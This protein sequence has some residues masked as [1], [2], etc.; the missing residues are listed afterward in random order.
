[1]KLTSKSDLS[2][3][4]KCDQNLVLIN[5]VTP[6]ARAKHE[7]FV[8]QTVHNELIL[9][10]LSGGKKFLRRRRQVVSRRKSPSARTHLFRRKI[11]TT[12]KLNFQAVVFTKGI[13]W[14]RKTQNIFNALRPML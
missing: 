6:K 4:T 7:P 14:S 2:S 1:M 5:L 12:E 8:Q 10:S 9:R 13:K 11:Q 3:T